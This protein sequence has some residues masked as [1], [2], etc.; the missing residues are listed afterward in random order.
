[1]P[2]SLAAGPTPQ[3]TFILGMHR[4]GT[5]MLARII[6]TLGA[7]R[8]GI[9]FGGPLLDA[10][11]ADNA[12]GYWESAPVVAVQEALTR[13]LF[14]DMLAPAIVRGLP[15]GWL[16]HPATRSAAA[17]L[18][19]ILAERLAEGGGAF[20]FKDPR[21]ALFLPLWREVLGRLGARPRWLLMLR[22]PRAVAGS[23]AVRNDVPRALGEALWL[24][25]HAALL[26]EVGPELAYIG[27]Y[28]AFLAAPGPELA[29]LAAV[30]D[31]PVPD[32]V[33]AADL[34]REAL[35]HQPGHGPPP[36]IAL[37]GR[38]HALLA[39]AGEPWVIAAAAA[40]LLTEFATLVTAL[41]GSPGW[42]A[43]ALDHDGPAESGL[44]LVLPAG[45]AGPEGAPLRP[46]H[47]VQVRLAAGND[48]CRPIGGGLMLHANPPGQPP[49]RL[50][51]APLPD[52]SQGMRFETQAST[53]GAGPPMRLH[54]RLEDAAETTLAT[55]V[56]ELPPGS[57]NRLSWVLP[58]CRGGRFTLEVELRPEAS[59]N[60]FGGV[61]LLNPRLGP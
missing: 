36:V 15:P 27:R 51:F 11:A 28:E 4:S 41:D 52:W 16:A 25:H 14:G 43:H 22:D 12:L 23:L 8:P 9:G 46:G 30:L 57:D 44:R 5:S 3:V 39:A 38:L 61:T 17:A 55:L 6:G 24:R 53:Y 60:A 56:L 2:E 33:Q 54:G 50:S 40:P 19:A 37:A 31:L 45:L 7:G 49:P 58:G 32:A 59:H 26:A 20:C 48:Y 34:V 42:L 21:S 47:G 29:R 18:E 35:Q 1:M 10:P 13:A